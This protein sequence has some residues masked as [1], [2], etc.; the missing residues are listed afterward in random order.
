[1]P[2]QSRADTAGVTGDDRKIVAPDVPF[3]TRGGEISARGLAVLMN[4]PSLCWLLV[5]LL[6][7]V[8]YAGYLALHEV[9][10]RNLRSGLF[11]FVGLRNFARLAAD[12][13]FWLSL[14]HTAVF[15]ALVVTLEILIGMGLALVAHDTR[16]WLSR[17]T[18]ALILVP[19]AVPPIVNGLLWSFI[20]NAQIG[21][22]NRLLY[23]L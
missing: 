3:H 9:S 13:V 5:V 18:L 7:P 16:V 1:L 11:P 2:R 20:F 21:Y 6:Y 22:L 17:V 10:L 23:A 15:V 4:L 12:D 19:W 8:L 14:A